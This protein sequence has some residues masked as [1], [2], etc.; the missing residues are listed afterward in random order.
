M[1]KIL[2]FIIFPIA[3]AWLSGCGAALTVTAPARLPD[4]T[5]INLDTD[6]RAT[7]TAIYGFS[8]DGKHLLCRDGANTCVFDASTGRAVISVPGAAALPIRH[9][10]AIICRPHKVTLLDFA[11]EKP[12]EVFQFTSRSVITS[13][14][15]SDN[16]RMAA[17]GCEG[18]TCLWDTTTGLP[19]RTLA[20]QGG[21]IYSV[22]FR[23]DGRQIVTS[24]AEVCVRPTGVGKL[25]RSF[26]HK[27]A[28]FNSFDV[29]LRIHA[30]SAGGQAFVVHENWVVPTP[31]ECAGSIRISRGATVYNI[32][33]KKLLQTTGLRPIVSGDRKTLLVPHE[34]GRKFIVYDFA[35]MEK[36][37]EIVAD[38]H[39]PLVAAPGGNLVGQVQT[40]LG[41][42][43]K[44]SR[45]VL[46][47]WD[48]T[49]AKI[50]QEI[51]LS[52]AGWACAAIS[53]DGKTATVQ[54]GRSVR[55]FDVETGKTLLEMRGRGAVDGTGQVVFSPNGSKAA[56]RFGGA[57]TIINL[58]PIRI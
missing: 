10:K 43:I 50:L 54:D 23:P 52:G 35:R 28:D 57:V 25:T 40:T 22:R 26:R 45:Q 55:I 34:S 13:A 42:T 14:A 11:G 5:V 56:I 36:T 33:G 49:T 29:P 37:G 31:P 12:G 27:R 39:S 7:I 38:V 3:A 41:Q 47:F 46:R 44:T 15:L 48:S 4:G 51:F 58:T 18:A 24:A 9:G 17:V 21:A 8:P 16:G 20:G 2:S 53:G 1:R 32:Y 30:F 19:V 6:E